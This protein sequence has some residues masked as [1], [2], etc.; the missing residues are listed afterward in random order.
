MPGLDAPLDMAQLGSPTRT[1]TTGRTFLYPRADGLMWVKTPSSEYALQVAQQAVSL[2]ANGDMEIAKAGTPPVEPLAWSG[3]WHSGTTSVAQDTTVY[4]GGLASLKATISATAGDNVVCQSDVFPVQGGSTLLLD[5]DMKGEVGAQFTCELQTSA[6]ASNGAPNFFATGT[7]VTGGAPVVFSNTN[8]THATRALAIPAN[9]TLARIN[10]R[11]GHV[12]SDAAAHTGYI[13]N[14]VARMDA[15][16]APKANWP[17]VECRLVSTTNITLSGN[18]SID[19]FTT[20]AGDR[21]LVAG[22]TTAADNGI[23]LADAAAWIRAGDADTAAELA[24]AM[25]AIQAGS[26]NGGTRWGTS[27]RATDVV[28]STAMNWA[29]LSVETLEWQMLFLNANYTGTTGGGIMPFKTVSGT[30]GGMTVDS[31][32]RH[33]VAKA[34]VYHV[35]VQFEFTNAGSGYAIERMNLIRGGTAIKVVETVESGAGWHSGVVFADWDCQAGDIFEAFVA[36]Q[37]AGQVQFENTRN[38]FIAHRLATAAPAGAGGG[39]GAAGQTVASPAM[40]TAGTWYSVSHTLGVQVREVTAVDSSG[41]TRLV[42]WRPTSGSIASSI[43]VRSGLGSLA[44]GYYNL[45]LEG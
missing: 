23:Y 42:D 32:G 29:N 15:T 5:Y 10:F 39:G 25:V 40:A 27:F 35:A 38:Q 19:S 6:D 14:V 41:E 17:L 1:P 31:F 22:Q 18:Q 4:A 45:Y 12:G 7:Y 44:A 37:T 26:V 20:A 11:L 8:W 21:I 2:I 34:G 28:G 13:D 30:G 24:G 3:F 36:C 16:A 43:D 9:H 33:V